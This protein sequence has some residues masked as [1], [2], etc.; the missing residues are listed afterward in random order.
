MKFA[1]G[2][3]CTRLISD[4]VDQR[5]MSLQITRGH[6]S[7]SSYRNTS[8]KLSFK[9]DMTT[10]NYCVN[11]Q[12]YT[13]QVE[14]WNVPCCLP[15]QD[16]QLCILEGIK[17]QKWINLN[18]AICIIGSSTIRVIL[19]FFPYIGLWPSLQ[20][21][22]ASQHQC[23]SCRCWLCRF[24]SCCECSART[25]SRTHCWT[26]SSLVYPLNPIHILLFTCACVVC[27]LRIRIR[28]LGMW[29]CT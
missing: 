11:L 10:C 12:R 27:R 17:L 23:N 6:G 24:S 9:Y 19:L 28:L 1:W 13:G 22:S 7:I 4:D 15:L 2:H 14:R 3:T 8:E 29:E 26:V 5:L 16:L 18:A 20:W 25:S 21:C